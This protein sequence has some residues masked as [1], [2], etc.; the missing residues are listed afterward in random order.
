MAVKYSISTLDELPGVG[1]ATVKKLNEAGIES[2]E[3][4]EGLDV[5]DLIEIGISKATAKKI[6]R[7]FSS[8]R[9]IQTMTA[10]EVDKIEKKKGYI[11]TFTDLDDL[12]GGGFKE[13]YLYEAYGQFATGKSEIAHTLAVRAQF[14]TEHGGLN[15]KVVF[16][17]TENTFSTKRVKEIAK[18][19]AD[20]YGLNYSEEQVLKNIIVAK[21]VTSTD[22]YSFVISSL[23]N[24]V[25]K[26]PDVK[27]IIIDSVTAP[28]RAEYTD[29]NEL[30]KRQ[31]KIGEI[32]MKLHEI[33][34]GMFDGNYRIVYYTNQVAT[35][36]GPFINPAAAETHVGG[37][38]LG[39][40]AQYRLYLRKG[41]DNIRIARLVDAHDLPSQECIF[42]IGP[43][44]IMPAR[45]R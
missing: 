42:K 13:S 24:I 34:I 14:P 43:G 44:G 31:K 21:A 15:G 29:L 33:A 26:N 7:A 4:L 35:R 11:K 40:R 36:I 18:Y 17:D 1:A 5:D 2:L 6:I 30:P 45:G 16:V 39:H 25:K 32:L 20:K 9:E 10:D 8:I 23:P 37:N 27:L 41:R 19:W 38:I 22:L 12:L 28:F 3:D